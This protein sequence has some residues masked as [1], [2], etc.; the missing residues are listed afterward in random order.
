MKRVLIIGPN[1]HY[2]VRSIECAFQQLGWETRAELYDDPIH[3]YNICNKIRYKIGN[4]QTLQAASRAKYTNYICSAYDA[5]QPELV[6]VINGMN[7]NPKAVAHFHKHSKI[8]FWLLDSITRFPIM[9][10]NLVHAD[11]VFCY[12][13]TDINILQKQL[14]HTPVHFL[15]QAA[16]ATLYHSLVCEKKYDIVFAGDIFNSHK[17][18]ALLQTIVAHYPQLRIAIWG[19]YKPWFKNPIRWLFRERRDIY[20]N[21][22]VSAAELNEAYN[23]SRIVLNIHHEQQKD[24]A[25]P[26][27]YEICAAGAYQICDRNPFIESVFPNGEVALYTTKE[28][29]FTA[30]DYALSHDMSQQAQE[31][32]RIIIEE[33]TFI[34]RIKYMLDFLQK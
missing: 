7:L 8:A 10:H 22:N 23:S 34:K 30:I 6:L 5:W 9:L 18:Q 1:F 20:R 24:G 27:V 13:K 25:N 19:Q 31:A 2:F 21:H 26:K 4:K 33:H 17:R 12:E 3:P 29:M 11:T 15:A 14:L 28:E 16:D 32:H